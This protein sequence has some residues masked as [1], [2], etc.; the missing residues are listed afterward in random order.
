M[1]NNEIKE[2]IDTLLASNSG[3]V[4]N[5]QIMELDIAPSSDA[6]NNVRVK[7]KDSLGKTHD[8]LHLAY[9][10]SYITGIGLYI[11][12]LFAL[13]DDSFVTFKTAGRVNE[14]GYDHITGVIIQNKKGGNT[15]K[16]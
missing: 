5:V 15:G 6:L 16:K 11:T 4:Q 12:L 7:Y 13:F 2:D 8:K 1:N 14:H 10:D 3:V 9:P